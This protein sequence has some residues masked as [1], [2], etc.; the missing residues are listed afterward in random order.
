[1]LEVREKVAEILKKELTDACFELG[2]EFITVMSGKS[3]PDGDG[4]RQEILERCFE[5]GV[6]FRV[7]GGTD[8]D[9]RT[10]FN[11]KLDNK[12][13]GDDVVDAEGV[14]IF[15]D[16]VSAI[17]LKNFELDCAEGRKGFFL[18]ERQ[19]VKS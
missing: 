7:M 8:D 3:N 18:R 9:G 1:M 10:V 4:I 15:L 16:P 19:A 12:E 2:G 14:K 17:H 5:F 6:G 13:V 11:I